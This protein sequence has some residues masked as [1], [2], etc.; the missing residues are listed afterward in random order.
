MTTLPVRGISIKSGKVTKKPPK[1]S[2][3]KKIGQKAKADRE[4]AKWK[5]KSK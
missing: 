3:S 5:A 4:A 1:M 2:V